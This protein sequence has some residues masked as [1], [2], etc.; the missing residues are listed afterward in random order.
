MISWVT[1]G[2]W[3]GGFSTLGK[4]SE[5]LR[6]HIAEVFE[7]LSRFVTSARGNSLTSNTISAQSALTM[8][9][10]GIST[11]SMNINGMSKI[12]DGSNSRSIVSID[13]KKESRYEL[14]EIADETS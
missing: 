8:T 2:K 13:S 10:A 9:F 4:W 7:F 14:E 5:G 6:K 12:Q 3:G 11:L 1:M